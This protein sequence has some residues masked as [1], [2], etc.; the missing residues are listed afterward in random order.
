MKCTLRVTSQSSNNL[1]A[2]LKLVELADFDI[3]PLRLSNAVLNNDLS[4]HR[5][6][7]IKKV[8]LNDGWRVETDAW[9]DVKWQRALRRCK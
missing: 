8:R 4:H 3:A 7:G 1:A 9:L 2:V 6:N 5:I